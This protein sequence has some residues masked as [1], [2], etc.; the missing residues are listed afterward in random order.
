MITWRMVWWVIDEHGFMNHTHLA[1]QQWV[2]L[3]RIL[4]IHLVVRSALSLGTYTVRPYF[5]TKEDLG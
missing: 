1:S 4:R 2:F 3:T 5:F